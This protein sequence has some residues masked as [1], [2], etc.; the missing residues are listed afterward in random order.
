MKD[1]GTLS[2]ALNKLKLEEGYEF[3]F[4]LLD[5]KIEIK[6]LNETYGVEDFDVDKVLRFEGMSNPD[7]NAILYAIT[8]DNGKKGVLVDGYGISGGQ[9]SKEMLKKLDL[10]E[11]RPI[12]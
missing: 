11:N 12:N 10:K 7:D 4:N 1:Y 8:T 6:S 3:D 2:Q 5:E 9:V